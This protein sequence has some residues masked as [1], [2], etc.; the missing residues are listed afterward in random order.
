MFQTLK[1]QSARTLWPMILLCT[2]LATAATAS[3]KEIAEVGVIHPD[4]RVELDLTR[5]TSTIQVEDGNTVG[6]S[7][8]RL[9]I[10]NGFLYIVRLG[11][12]GCTNEV[13]TTTGG[14][15]LGE[16]FPLLPAR[17]GD[18]LYGTSD[19]QPLT[20][21]TG[22][23]RPIAVISITHLLQCENVSC[24]G[25]LCARNEWGNS[26]DCDCVYFDVVDGV[27][28]RDPGNPGCEKR[29]V[30]PHW[31]TLSSSVDPVHIQSY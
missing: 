18:G 23:L 28:V 29:I 26:V 12:D 30:F 24:D 1:T 11:D 13:L 3:G 6:V 5:F 16:I 10:S 19:P 14:Y 22:V 20:E 2:L 8:V 27:L 7:K 4:G 9:K 17:L 21:A 15:T 25:G 31:W